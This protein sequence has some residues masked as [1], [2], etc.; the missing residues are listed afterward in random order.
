[1]GQDFRGAIA[2][3]ADV[4]RWRRRCGNCGAKENG[5]K[6]QAHGK[7]SK[8]VS[9]QRTVPWALTETGGE[10]DLAPLAGRRFGE[11]QSPGLIH[12]QAF[13]LF[14]HLF[15]SQKAHYSFIA[16]FFALGVQEDDG[17]QT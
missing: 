7:G 8:R 9:V 13:H 16:D 15:G 4:Q 11:G 12:D 17:W 2:Q 14:Q 5:G 3:K 1:M 10:L 6:P